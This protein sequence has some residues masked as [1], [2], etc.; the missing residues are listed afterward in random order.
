MHL[1]QLAERLGFL[2]GGIRAPFG[3][4]VHDGPQAVGLLLESADKGGDAG[5]IAEVRLQRLCAKGAK[6]VDAVA[7]AAVGKDDREAVFQQS[8]GTMQPDPLA[9]SGDENRGLMH[10]NPLPVMGG[11]PT[12]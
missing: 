5:F 3:G 9:G 1:E 8:L 12:H 6:P 11:P 10:E 2:P 7:F 4:V